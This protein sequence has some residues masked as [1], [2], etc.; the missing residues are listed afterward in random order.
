MRAPEFEGRRPLKGEINLVPLINVVFLLLI[1]FMLSSTLATPDR[2]DV[3]LPESARAQATESEPIVVMID[4]GGGFAVNNAPVAIGDLEPAL[5]A[6]R[7]V[8]PDAAILLKADARATT[9]DVV[10]VLRRARA[11][12]IERVALAAREAAK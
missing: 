6:A 12:G 11:A 2:F 4:A 1:F 3:D 8:A 9:A 7:A 5:A 10:N